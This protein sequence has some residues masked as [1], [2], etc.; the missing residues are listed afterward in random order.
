LT[1][2]VI[3]AEVK[4]WEAMQEELAGLSTRGKRIVVRESSHNIQLDA[5]QVIIDAIREIFE[6]EAK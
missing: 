6:Q 1:I 3:Q 2:E 5:P 4:A